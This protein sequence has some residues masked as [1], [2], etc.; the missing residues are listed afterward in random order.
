MFGV[1]IV[2]SALLPVWLGWVCFPLALCAVIP[3]I[4]WIAFIGVGIWV[5]L[6]SVALWLRLGSTA[7]ASAAT[8]SA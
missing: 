1:A 3:P 2:R 4:G 6:V 5:L 8:A 7:G